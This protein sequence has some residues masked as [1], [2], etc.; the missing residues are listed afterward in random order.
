MILY[1]FIY[2]L[3]TTAQISFVLLTV[4]VSLN[5]YF[6]VSSKIE[7]NNS[8]KAQLKEC[9]KAFNYVVAKTY[10]GLNQILTHCL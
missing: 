3:I 6:I 7:I 9:K 5:Q 8:K 10:L 4:S 1:P 2:P